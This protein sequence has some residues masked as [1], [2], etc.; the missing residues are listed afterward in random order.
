MSDLETFSIQSEKLSL[1]SF[2]ALNEE[3]KANIQYSSIVPPSLYDD[4]DFGGV[5]VEYRIPLFP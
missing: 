2:V 1:E 5:Y 4:N 3:E